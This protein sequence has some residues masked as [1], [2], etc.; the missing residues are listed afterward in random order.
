[1]YSEEH[2]TG[3]VPEIVPWDHVIPKEILDKITTTEEAFSDSITVWI[4]PL[5]ATQEYSG[6]TSII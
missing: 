6:V 3:N 5:D 2:D 4:D 1:M